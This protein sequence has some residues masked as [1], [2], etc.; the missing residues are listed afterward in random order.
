M[1]SQAGVV[2]GMEIEVVQE[3]RAEQAGQI[4][5]KTTTAARMRLQTPMVEKKATTAAQIELKIH[6]VELKTTTIV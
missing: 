1:E 2:E 6:T 3:A 5:Q 4:G